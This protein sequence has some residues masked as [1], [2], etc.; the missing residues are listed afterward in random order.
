LQLEPKDHD[1]LLQDYLKSKTA[2]CD[3]LNAKSDQKKGGKAGGAE[4]DGAGDKSCKAFALWPEDLMDYLKKR[5]ASLLTVNAYLLDTAQKASPIG[6]IA[7]PHATSQF[8]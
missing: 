1:E 3:T 7:R 6:G 8:S 2:A 4:T 5:M